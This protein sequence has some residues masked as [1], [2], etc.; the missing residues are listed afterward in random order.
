MALPFGIIKDI[1]LGMTEISRAAAVSI[2][3]STQIFVGVL[4]SIFNEEARM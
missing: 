4:N 2:S 1:P 3:P